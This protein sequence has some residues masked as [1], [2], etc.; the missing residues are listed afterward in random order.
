MTRVIPFLFSF[1][2]FQI[3]AQSQV[4]YILYDEACM[5]RF[6]MITDIDKTPYVT[7]SM[8]AGA[9]RVAQLDIGKEP[10]KWVKDVPGK[11]T[12]CA[13]LSFD[14]GVVQSI[15]NGSLT[16]HIVRKSPTH[17]LVTKVEKATFFDMNNKLFNVT[18]A[19]AEF[20]MD[21]YRLNSSKNL[22][23]PTSQKAVY[24]EGTIKYDCLTGYI[25]TKKDR[26]DSE[27][28]KEY[29]IIPEMGIVNK[30]SVPYKG[31]VTNS[32]K[33][34]R[35]NGYPFNEFI[36]LACAGDSG[37]NR[38]AYTESAKTQPVGYEVL[39]EKSGTETPTSYGSKGPCPP[40]KHSGVHVVQKGET[41]YSISRRYGVSVAQIKSWNGIG[42]NNLI[43]LCQELF[44]T[45]PSARTQTSTG[46]STG[47]SGATNKNG[48]INWVENTKTEFHIV[49][50]GES[51]AQLAEM[52]GYTESRFRKMNSLGKYERVYAGQKL[53]TSDCACPSLETDNTGMPLPYNT[54]TPRLT[55]KGNPDVYFRPIKVHLVNKGE[56]LFAIARLY[57]TTVDRIRELNGLT[58]KSKLTE[59]Q[60]L[61]VQ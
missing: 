32:L 34:D 5:D 30:R 1:F 13:A 25:F 28:Y 18:M 35:V 46:T 20:D 56:S 60:R 27:A 12:N 26:W 41:L 52:Y 51:V 31:A 17:Y 42:K 11:L 37:N 15:N 44:M 2:L 6:E 59:N 39:T 4:Y 38:V 14:K 57:D 50:P 58:A 10:V 45:P 61:Y 19:D 54:E 23:T 33:L 21:M 47:S 8:K 16:L 3:A 7:Y 9:G 24:L 40:A 36:K 48:G 55:T 22:G 29:I 49:K 43:S 53:Y